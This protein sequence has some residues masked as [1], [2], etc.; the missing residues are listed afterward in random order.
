MKINTKIVKKFI[1]GIIAAAAA[2]SLCAC[3]EVQISAPMDPAT[4][5][6]IESSSIQVTESIFRLMELRTAYG[7]T[8]AEF[9][10]SE[11]DGMTMEE[12]IKDSV[13][14]EVIRLCAVGNMADGMAVY[15]TEEE[16]SQALEEAQEA[17][18]EISALY[19]L[20][21][22]AITI[23]DAESLYIKQALYEKV[24]AELT[25]EVTM[26]I[27]ESD[28]KVIQVNYCLL[29]EE[30]TL[31]EAETLRSTIN[32]GEFQTACESAGYTPVMNA[33]IRKGDMIAAFESVAFSLGD[34]EVSE[35]TETIE[36]IY[37]IQ[38]VEDYLSA[39]SSANYNAVISQEKKERFEEVYDA[40]SEGTALRFNSE[41]WEEIS[42]AG[43]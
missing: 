2:L 27:S 31:T 16:N 11:V 21:A 6:T 28:T 7:E 34:G 20:S 38:C 18:K 36:G 23:T 25:G 30:A 5:V 35:C 12:Y 32:A 42:V 26:E 17:Y 33:Q 9:Y 22:H 39:E 43:L 3:S 29:P 10:A 15:L 40:Y 37:I 8:S 24:Y 13:K 1:S 14:E 19:D 4:L 41:V